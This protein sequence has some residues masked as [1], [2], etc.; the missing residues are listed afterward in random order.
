MDLIEY[1]K[2][3]IDHFTDLKE[4]RSGGSP[5]FAFEHNLNQDQ[6]DEIFSILNR[7]K[8]E[9]FKTHRMVWI[10]CCT[11]IGYN[12]EGS[13]YWDSFKNKISYLD[14][15]FT[16]YRENLRSFFIWFEKTFNGIVPKGT[17]ANH[18]VNISHPITHAILP[19]QFQKLFVEGLDK[20]S[21]YAHVD[22]IYRYIYFDT[23][24]TRFKKFLENEDFFKCI[25]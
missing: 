1:N 15:K 3:L 21:Q 19:K 13:E 9:P 8:I 10:I 14:E 25:T 5:I 18:F 11:E 23:R 6:I 4:K 17:W 12:Y 7:T 24:S 2:I 16:G 22:T 20:F